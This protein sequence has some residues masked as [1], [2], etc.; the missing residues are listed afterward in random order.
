M[1]P[2][3]EYELTEHNVNWRTDLDAARRLGV[4]AIR[5]GVAWPLV[6]TAPGVFDWS[7]LDERL[8]YAHDKL[9][10]TVV[11]DLV[12]Y[13]TPTWLEGSFADSAYPAAIAEFAG[14]FAERYRGI[15]DHITPLNEPLTTAS[16]CG[17]RGVWPPA[18]TGWAG[19]VTVMMNI[20]LGITASIRAARDANPEIVIMHVEASSLYE[21]DVE[22]LE[23]HAAKLRSLGMLST[24]LI[25]GRV[26]ADHPLYDWLID[27]GASPEH[28]TALCTSPAALDLLGVN[29]YPMLTPRNLV[30]ADTGVSQVVS[31]GGAAGLTTV[32]EAFAARYDIP[33]VI[34]ETSV[35]GDDQVRGRWVQDSIAAVQQLRQRGMDIR[36]YTWWP[37][38]DFV[39]WS[40][41]SGGHNVEEFQVD[42]QIVASRT[43]T[44]AP[45]AAARQLNKTPFLRR[46]GLIRLEEQVDGHL[47]RVSTGAADVFAQH[48]GARLK[49]PSETPNDESA[50]A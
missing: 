13:G 33:L 23:S 19:W 35:E 2:L 26:D 9:A 39:D 38:F 29:Y 6:H 34:T 22:E 15:V 40:Y 50:H 27:F 42:E 8:D 36:G 1:L 11:A 41:A 14:A 37:L 12:H 16:F 7:M 48:S 4:D 25:L 24:D 3:D 44:A 49:H 30:P 32:L 5:Y 28:L 20:A 10:L 47:A 43:A 18:L 46:M 45:A 17:L 21:T 31:D